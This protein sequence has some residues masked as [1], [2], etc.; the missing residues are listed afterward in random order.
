MQSQLYNVHVINNYGCGRIDTVQVVILNGCKLYVPTAFTPNYD[1]LNDKFRIYIGCLKTLTRF[2][3]FN[4]W[5]QVIFTTKNDADTW[6]G[7]YK[8][9]EQQAGSYIWMAEGEYKSGKKFT[10][11]GIVTLIR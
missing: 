7:R 5:G 10:E 2:T 8:G 3:I 6:D 1:G 9:I 11:K 4:R